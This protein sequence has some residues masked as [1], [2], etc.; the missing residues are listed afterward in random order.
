MTVSVVEAGS[1]G[2]VLRRLGVLAAI[3]PLAA[4]GS[5]SFPLI[6]AQMEAAGVDAFWIGVN[7]AYA[8]L[9][10]V[11]ASWIGPRVLARVRVGFLMLG[12]V[13]C[14]ALPLA[15]FPFTESYAA[16]TVLRLILGVGAG[17]GYLSAEFW[18]VSVATAA[19]RGRAVGYYALAVASGMSVGPP[20]LWLT[21]VEG[22]A[23]FFVCGAVALLSCVG[24]VLAWRTAPTPQ[25]TVRRTGAHAF[26]RSDPSPLWSVTFF[27]AVEAGAFGLLWVWALG[28]GLAEEQAI[29]VIVAVAIGALALQPVIGALIDRVPPRPLLICGA[30]ACVAG[31]LAALGFALVPAPW[32]LYAAM[33]VWGGLSGGL[34]TVS[35]ASMGGRYVGKDL[36]AANAAMVAA[37]GIGALI[38]PII[39]GGAMSIGGPAGL[40]VVT[41]VG[42]IA[43]LAL[44]IRRAGA[45]KD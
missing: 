20:I 36:A 13:F 38:G 23:P 39:V 44:L 24:I 3:A 7:G 14:T 26:F 19:R 28:L 21:G 15:L 40:S 9:A 30:V 31:P 42:A 10:V 1:P 17:A 37:Y 43:L 16:W 18:V 12:A 35:L 11:G 22:W 5:M 6:S 8:A 34:Y 32:A 25:S 4:A 2:Y 33:L 29:G 45:R 41:A 27:G